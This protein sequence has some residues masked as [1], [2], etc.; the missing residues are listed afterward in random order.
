MLIYFN[1]A[2]IQYWNDDRLKFPEFS[3]IQNKQL[4][5][6]INQ[7]KHA[8]LKRILWTP[9]PFFVNQKEGKVLDNPADNT[10]FKLM[11]TGNIYNNRVEILNHKIHAYEE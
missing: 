9:D 5:N 1:V 6:N 10:L 2:L 8:S 4:P 11:N 7:I 3:I